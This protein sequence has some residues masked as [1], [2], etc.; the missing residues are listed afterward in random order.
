[1]MSEK[2]LTWL[3]LL[4]CG[5][6][7][8]SMDSS[9]DSRAFERG[10]G[11]A[12]CTRQLQR[13]LKG[14]RFDDVALESEF[15][16]RY[17]DLNIGRIRAA[18]AA[19]IVLVFMV[20]V[21]DLLTAPDA[22]RVSVFA[23]K[24]GLLLP[25]PLITLWVAY[26][27]RYYTRIDRAMFAAVVTVGF[28]FAAVHTQL[29]LQGFVQPHYSAML[30][31]AYSYFLSA[32]LW[33]GCVIAALLVTAA[34]VFGDV[35]AQLPINELL[36]SAMH[37]LAANLIGMVGSFTTERV[38]RLDYLHAG[39]ASEM[40]DIDRV[41]S[42]RSA[43]SF[44]RRLERWWLK[45]IKRRS[46]VGIMLI[47]IDYF[48]RFDQSCGHYAA[49]KALR[50]IAQGIQDLRSTQ[51]CFLAR[52]DDD[53]F[54]VIMRDASTEALQA[55]A[56]EIRDS[57]RDLHLSHPDSPIADH[58]TVTI[59]G[60]VMAPTEQDQYTVFSDSVRAELE[61]VKRCK[62]DSIWIESESLQ[63][64]PDPESKVTPLRR[65]G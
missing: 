37:L 62:R 5:R 49:E 46:A 61:R 31:V 8:R 21:L 32:L 4:H 28:I 2:G 45:A 35:Y 52:L 30:V 50:T 7:V 36:Y 34:A 15:R 59:A 18:I 39:S 6:R 27:P 25:V 17:I 1:M 48:R 20:A 12:P 9:S 26:H 16:R 42:L 63:S 44:A 19:A 58:L 57:I 51:E 43:D 65:S 23:E 11:S 22:I 54:G 13:G 53:G 38:S 47:D 60:R 24:L 33:P 64:P 40:A 56:N 41:T 10:A 3:K 14:L 55:L 29:S